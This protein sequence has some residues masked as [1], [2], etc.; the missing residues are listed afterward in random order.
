MASLLE[1]GDGKPYSLIQAA[2]NA[3]DSGSTVRAC[4][5]AA[6]ANTYPEALL[7]NNKRVTLEG[8]LPECVIVVSG[9]GGGAAP[10][11]LV[12][13]TGG[14]TVRNFYFSNVGSSATYVVEANV[15]EDWFHDSIVDGGNVAKCIQAQFMTNMT[16]LNGLAAVDASCGGQVIG[17]HCTAY[18]HSQYGFKGNTNLAMWQACL[19]ADCNSLGFQSGLAQYCEW[20]VGDDLTP[21]GT[22]SVIRNLPIAAMAFTG[23]DYRLLPTTLAWLPGISPLMT[24]RL[25]NRRMRRGPNARIVAGA[26]DPWP[27]APSFLTGGSSI[28]RW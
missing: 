26:F 2:I 10:A 11:L 28:R 24:D 19:A 16:Y 15:A 14:V 6:S 23:A 25:A 13:G 3:G 8:D 7:V 27:V 12:T 22:Q 9:A 21:P 18:H 4:A 1:V 5:K 17:I 20:N